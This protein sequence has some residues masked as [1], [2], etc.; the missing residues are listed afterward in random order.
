M[1]KIS[2]NLVV[3][4]LSAA[5]AASSLTGCGAVPISS[6][7]KDAAGQSSDASGDSAFA[8][9]ETDTVQWFN[10]S[11]AI[12]TYANGQDYNMFGGAK[13][14]MMMEMQYQSMLNE[15]WDVSDRASADET[16]D[17]ILTE[18]HRDDFMITGELLS[19]MVEECGEEGLEDFLI[20]EFDESAE[21]A[22]LDVATYNMYKE[23]GEAAID[24]WDYCRALSLLSF[25][26]M[27]GYYTKEEALDKSLE[28][29][30][31]VQPLFGSWDELIDS[32]LRGYEYWAGADSS[33]RREIY[34]ELLAADDN[35]FRVDYNTTLE[36]T[37]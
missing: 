3:V 32:Y 1:N 10:A 7:S 8:G 6:P 24:G 2:I 20:Q 15:S 36:K 28:I 29:A 23:Y 30:Q 18:G 21:E 19:Q 16:L 13:P 12:I 27:A 5:L 34:E 9:S 4:I 35:P 11:Y 17:W 31:T 14:G 25:Y 33:A 26:Y 22:Q 37:W